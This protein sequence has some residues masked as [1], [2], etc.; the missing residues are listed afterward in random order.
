MADQS[1]LLQLQQGGERRLQRPFYRAVGAQHT[2]QVHHLQHVEPQVT[3]IVL[4]G[5]GQFSGRHGRQPVAFLV[6]A[7]AD[8]GDNAQ[9][10]GVGVERFADQLIGHMGAIE[11][12]GIDMVYPGFDGGLQ[13]AHRFFWIFRRAENA[14]AGQLHGAVT[15]PIDLAIAERAA[16][17]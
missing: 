13:H 1:S 6:T 2:A 15:Q 16:T 17:G 11:I 14:G 8:L 9:I 10:V 4:D 5:L 12:R 3:Q 7:G